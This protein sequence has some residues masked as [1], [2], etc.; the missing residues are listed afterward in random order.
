MIENLE[1]FFY[2]IDLEFTFI[3]DIYKELNKATWY[4]SRHGQCRSD[5]SKELSL[6]I[7]DVMPFKIDDAGFFKNDPGWNYR[8]HKD[9]KRLAAV[10]MLMVE[11]SNNFCALV[12]DDN[13]KNKDSIKTVI[14][15]LREEE[16]SD[17][18]MLLD[19]SMTFEQMIM[20]DGFV[21]INFDLWLLL[22]RYEIPSIF[23]SSKL[24]PETRFNSKEFVC[25]TDKGSDYVFIVTQ[26]MYKR[27][28]NKFPEY[29]IIITD[30]E[31]VKINLDNLNKGSC[32]TNIQ[33]A[34]DNYVTI[35]DYID[36]VFEKDISTKYKPKQKGVRKIKG[37]GIELEIIGGDV[38]EPKETI[39]K[40]KA[41]KLK[42]T[43]VLEEE[44]EEGEQM[45]NP[46][47]EIF[48][49]LP[50][51]KRN[52]KKQREKKIIVNPASKKTRRRRLPENFEIVG[53]VDLVI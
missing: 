12:Y 36:F 48:E 25:Y 34:I 1:D 27:T 8:I 10:N 23:V 28:G 29:T 37:I 44:L 39:V 32:L 45:I 11:N 41:K 6:L 26:A 7:Q 16:Q 24:I 53:D 5:I 3:D 49:I 31:D 35:K 21:A 20:Q 22:V 38:G 40:L 18:N 42:P 33:S 2:Q 51:K 15:I 9:S 13:F 4:T 30:K 17:A 43:L 46:V 50:V 47:E 52:T 14:N 19:N